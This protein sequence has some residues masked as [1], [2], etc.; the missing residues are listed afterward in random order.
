MERTTIKR[1]IWSRKLVI[2][3]GVV[4]A[5][6]LVLAII[7]GLENGNPPPA[8]TP[9]PAQFVVGRIYQVKPDAIVCFA[10]P[11]GT[12]RLVYA[13]VFR[14]NH[15]MINQEAAETFNCAVL[16]TGMDAKVE[17]LP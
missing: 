5:L 7:G 16:Y 11:D 15:G 17:L 4:L 10:E 14:H 1:R 8:V 12:D 9:T 2:T 6:L 3:C 13:G